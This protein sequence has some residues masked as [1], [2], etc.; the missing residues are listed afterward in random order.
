MEQ[1]RNWLSRYPQVA[2]ISDRFLP[3]VVFIAGFVWDTLTLTR[4][5]RMADNLVL[6]GYLVA[7]A[8]MIVVALRARLIQAPWM[9][10]F[11]PHVPLAMQ[12]LL[13]ALLSSY[14]V[15]YFKSASF[16]RTAGFL[17]L[18]IILLIGNEFLRDRL[19]NRRLIAVLYFFCLFSFLVFFLPVLLKRVG[20]V[21]F[22]ISGGISL[23]LA[24]A[25]FHIALP[26]DEV[27]RW[28]RLKPLTILVLSAYVVMH[29]LYFGGLIPPV[30]L[31]LKWSG[32]YHHVARTGSGYEVTY[33][34]PPW[35]RFWKKGDDPFYMAPGDSAY[36]FSAVFAP[37]NIKVPVLHCWSRYSAQSGWTI[38]DCAGFEVTGGREGGYR[39]FTVKR[40]ITPGRWRVDV[41]TE[42]GRVLGR[43]DFNVVAVPAGR[44]DLVRGII[45]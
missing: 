34:S 1:P 10:R 41:T 25:L 32:I 23:V 39:G 30:P 12:F 4:I 27:P 44:P 31:A 33:V 11:L 26:E 36:F 24:L 38:T 16:T 28:V 19:A 6:L 40:N 37:H 20:D 22:L 21:L 14:V 42:R 7:L 8:V 9:Q 45:K 3:I 18:L 35:Y 13:G 2:W 29:L 15:F 5:D 43:S 17:I